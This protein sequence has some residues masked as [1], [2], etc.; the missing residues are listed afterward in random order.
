LVVAVFAMAEVGETLECAKDRELH[1]VFAQM[2]G[3]DRDYITTS[4]M[5][6]VCLYC[7]CGTYWSSDLLHRHFSQ[8]CQ[9]CRAAVLID[10]PIASSVV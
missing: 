9:P 4:T 6:E 5:K 2:V 7:E 8:S 10:T 1:H 3:D